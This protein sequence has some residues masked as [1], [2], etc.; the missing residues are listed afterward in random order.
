MKQAFS[1]TLWQG[2][3]LECHEKPFFSVGVRGGRPFKVDPHLIGDSY[4]GDVPGDECGRL[5]VSE[6][7]VPAL[8]DSQRFVSE[9]RMLV[10]LQAHSEACR[11]K[12]NAL[13]AVATGLHD[14]A[15]SATSAVRYGKS[16]TDGCGGLPNGGCTGRIRESKGAVEGSACARQWPWRGGLCAWTVARRELKRVLI[17]C[18]TLVATAL[19]TLCTQGSHKTC[20]HLPRTNCHSLQEVVATLSS[21]L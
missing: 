21:G 2:T 4:Q 5:H 10:K 18:K 13:V 9:N 20:W 6:A 14:D 1:S 15:R 19:P 3:S 12:D 11:R 8:R 17:R 16:A 7:A